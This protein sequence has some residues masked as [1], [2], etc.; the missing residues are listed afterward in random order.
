MFLYIC[1]IKKNIVIF[2]QLFKETLV[3]SLA[4]YIWTSAF[5]VM[6]ILDLLTTYHAVGPGVTESNFILQWSIEAFGP[7]IGVFVVGL[8]FKTV[9][10]AV[11]ILTLN[12]IFRRVVNTIPERPARIFSQ[13]ALYAGLGIYLL[14]ILNG[15][16]GNLKLS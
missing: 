5:A 4:K 7:A 6:S 13:C 15:I 9:F 8:V 14:V 2:N 16:S 12:L 10:F 1:R 3:P 11:S